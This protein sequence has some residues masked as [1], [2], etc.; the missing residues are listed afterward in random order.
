MNRPELLS[1]HLKK[2]DGDPIFGEPWHAQALAMADLLIK[3]GTISAAQ[4]A[5]TLGREIVD[6]RIAGKPDDAETF[7]GAVLSSLEQLLAAGQNVSHAELATRRDEWRHAYE[8]TPHGL[9]VELSRG[10][11]ATRLK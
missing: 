5:E 7:Y 4:W 1:G 10:R 2:R 3:A 11:E 8:S 6:A 9:P